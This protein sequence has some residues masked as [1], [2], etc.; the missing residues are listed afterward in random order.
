MRY[1]YIALVL[2]VPPF[3]SNCR[4]NIWNFRFSLWFVSTGDISQISWLLRNSNLILFWKTVK[5]LLHFD[6]TNISLGAENTEQLVLHNWSKFW[7]GL[8]VFAIISS[9]M[10]LFLYASLITKAHKKV[11]PTNITFKSLYELL[12]CDI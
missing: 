11:K 8:N 2:E 6:I 7:S 9:Y 4:Q 12:K 5:F 3:Q 10:L 1:C